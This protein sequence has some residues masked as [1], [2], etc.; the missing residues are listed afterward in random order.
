MMARGTIDLTMF[1][2]DVGLF[3]SPADKVM[4]LAL[5]LSIFEFH[6]TGIQ[7]LGAT[8]YAFTGSDLRITV[9]DDER[10][11]VSSGTRTSP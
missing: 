3:P 1:R 10:I 6:Y 8:S 7:K 2:D 4:R 11:N 5:P 9:L